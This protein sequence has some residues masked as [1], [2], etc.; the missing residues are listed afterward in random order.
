MM[1]QSKGER[2]NYISIDIEASGPIPGKYSMLS[3]GACLVGRTSVSFYEELKP[4]NMNFVPEAL[5]VASLS[6]GDLFLTGAHPRDAMV[7]FQD[8]IADTSGGQA[9]VFVGFNAVFDWSFVNWYFHEFLGLNPFGFG[10][11]DIK[12]YYMGLTGETWARS[13]SGQLPAEFQPDHGQT[14]NALDD[15]RSQA[16]IFERLLYKNRQLHSPP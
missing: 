14:H 15:A 16:Q 6:L 8:W 2:E 4:L 11:V 5:N 12:S 13:T 10:G 7:R 3:V 9:P 1:S